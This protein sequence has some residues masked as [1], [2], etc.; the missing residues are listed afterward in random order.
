MK[1]DFI[2]E[3]P[4]SLQGMIHMYKNIGNY[5]G[6][7]ENYFENSVPKS[8]ILAP[9]SQVCYNIEIYR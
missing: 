4:K 6:S 3:E 5:L 7:K 8:V 1:S 9:I 2:S